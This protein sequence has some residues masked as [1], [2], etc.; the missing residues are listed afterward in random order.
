M[1]MTFTWHIPLRWTAL[2]YFTYLSLSIAACYHNSIFVVL[3]SERILKGLQGVF[4]STTHASTH[5]PNWYLGIILVNEE[6]DF[7]PIIIEND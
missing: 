1:P 7:C 5:R 2:S 4:F 6:Y 3:F